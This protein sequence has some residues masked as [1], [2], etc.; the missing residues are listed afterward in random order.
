MVLLAS[1]AIN[2]VALRYGGAT[3]AAP[4]GVSDV[5][6]VPAAVAAPTRNVPGLD[7]SPLVSSFRDAALPAWRGFC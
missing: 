2:S 7:R 6:S 1:A 3:G 4:A 5:A